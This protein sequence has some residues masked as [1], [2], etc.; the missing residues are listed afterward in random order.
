[1]RSRLIGAV[2]KV[3]Q[4]GSHVYTVLP[5]LLLFDKPV[6]V[7][8]SLNT[9]VLYTEQIKRIHIQGD[10]SQSQY[11]DRVDREEEGLKHTVWKQ[12]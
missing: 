9:K 10:S 3:S 8:C 12:Y 7:Y 2:C 6:G 1:M 5:S 11:A 4:C